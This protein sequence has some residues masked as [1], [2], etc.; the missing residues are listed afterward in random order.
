[1]VIYDYEFETKENKIQTKEKLS[2][3][4]YTYNIRVD[5]LLID[6]HECRRCADSLH[7]LVPRTVR[8]TLI[9]KRAIGSV[10]TNRIT[11]VQSCSFSFLAVSLSCLFSLTSLYP[12]VLLFVTSPCLS[13]FRLTPSFLSSSFFY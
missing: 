2:H 10:L 8:K 9:Q 6:F 7:R 5:R 1:M 4:T 13:P 11:T 3:N 12:F